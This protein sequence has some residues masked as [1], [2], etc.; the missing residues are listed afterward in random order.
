MSPRGELEGQSRSC[1]S[2]GKK[3]QYRSFTFINIHALTPGY[4]RAASQ[5]CF[6]AIA[7]ADAA[8]TA[9]RS[10]CVHA[11]SYALVGGADGSR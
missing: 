7:A 5:L 8:A 10:V 6:H 3:L 9:S 1:K 4:L 11:G 2:G